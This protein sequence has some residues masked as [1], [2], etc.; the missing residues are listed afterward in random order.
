MITI[1]S[2]Q[3]TYVSGLICSLIA[4]YYNHNYVWRTIFLVATVK[5]MAIST[6]L[7]EACLLH[8]KEHYENAYEIEKKIRMVKIITNNKNIFIQCIILKQ[9]TN[10]NSRITWLTKEC[11]FNTWIIYFMPSNDVTV[12]TWVKSFCGDVFI[13]SGCITIDYKWHDL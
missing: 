6:L 8:N 4:Y 12:Y 5:S 9:D 3:L 7:N 1:N 11:F 10:I 13:K 2:I